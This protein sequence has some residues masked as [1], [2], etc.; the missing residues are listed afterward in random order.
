LVFKLGEAIQVSEEKNFGKQYVAFDLETS[1]KNTRSDEIIE[2]GA[3][4]IKNGEVGE[5]YNALIKPSHPISSEITN[6]NR[7]YQQ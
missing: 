2:I 1:G 3:V 6:I 4:K 7:Y 5:E